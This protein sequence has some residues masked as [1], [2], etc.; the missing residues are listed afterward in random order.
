MANSFATA[1][2]GRGGASVGGVAIAIASVVGG[3]GGGNVVAADRPFFA[4]LR[5]RQSVG[6]RSRA[7][8]EGAI[9]RAA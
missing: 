2:L 8:S 7:G 4:Y 1:A 9:K 3:G 6:V 5:C